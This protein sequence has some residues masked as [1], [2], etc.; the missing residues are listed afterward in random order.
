MLC[1]VS[2]RVH[3]SI[4]VPAIIRAKMLVTSELQGPFS[5]IISCKLVRKHHIVSISHIFLI[6]VID[7]AGLFVP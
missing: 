5:V 6:G 2:S 3:E 4:T 7:L 1:F